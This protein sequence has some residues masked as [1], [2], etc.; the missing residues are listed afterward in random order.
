MSS[1][2]KTIDGVLE[3]VV[4]AVKGLHEGAGSEELG[5]SS[6]LVPILELLDGICCYFSEK[7][8]PTA[9]IT[10]LLKAAKM[11]SSKARADAALTAKVELAPEDVYH[12]C[13]SSVP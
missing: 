6:L 3:M 9:W 7:S 12:Y 11:F 8:K 4:A 13:K 2:I 1:S 10:I 5:D